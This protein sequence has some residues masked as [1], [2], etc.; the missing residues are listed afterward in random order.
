[1]SSEPKEAPTWEE[2]AAIVT[3]SDGEGTSVSTVARRHG[4][5]PQQLFARRRLARQPPAALPAA[6]QP[7]PAAVS[8]LPRRGRRRSE[9]SGNGVAAG[10]GEVRV[11]M[12]ANPRAIAAMNQALEAGA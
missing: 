2:T 7:E 11:S 10:G 8:V 3:E 1:M 9:A 5:V 12:D 6:A 4:P